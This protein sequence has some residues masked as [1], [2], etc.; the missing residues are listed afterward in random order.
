LAVPYQFRTSNASETRE[1]NA[2]RRK[3]TVVFS[4]QRRCRTFRQA[5]GAR[6]TG[7]GLIAWATIAELVVTPR[8]V[9]ASR[10]LE[11]EREGLHQAVVGFSRSMEGPMTK[12]GILSAGFIAA[13]R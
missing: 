3:K 13:R 2:N 10:V 5:V 7:Q 4:T 1:Q 11:K 6:G 9:V 12:L 8:A